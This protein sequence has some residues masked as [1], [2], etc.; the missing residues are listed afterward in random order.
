MSGCVIN[1]QNCYSWLITD[2]EEIKTALWR[3]LRFRDRNYFHNRAFRAK[4]W[5]GFVEFLKKESGRFLTG[6]LPEVEAA[7]K[8][9]R[10]DYKLVDERT[11]VGFLYDKVD[12]KFLDKW[13]HLTSADT[14]E[15]WE[16]LR[17]YQADL[18]NQSTNVG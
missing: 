18:A 9:L 17:D 14:Q 12:E 3:S 6:L 16:G 10:V 5:D 4:I 8:H 15:R 2:N 1:I 13:V 11:Q 7:L